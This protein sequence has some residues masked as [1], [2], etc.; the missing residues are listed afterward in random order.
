[1]ASKQIRVEQIDLETGEVVQMVALKPG[2]G[3]HPFKKEGFVQMSQAAMLELARNPV[4]GESM[5]VLMALC[6]VLDFDNFIRVSQT[7]LADLVGMS[8]PNVVRAMTELTE[9]GIL[10][11]GMRVG[12]NLTYRLSPT[13]GFKGQGSNFTKLMQDVSEF[14]SHAHAS[15]QDERSDLEEQGQQRLIE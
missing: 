6:A 3:R 7:E 2:K 1:M 15:D 11:K 4:S 10:I 8:R 5:R 12:R 13:F 9:R 14:A